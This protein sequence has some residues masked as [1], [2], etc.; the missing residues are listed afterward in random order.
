MEGKTWPESCRHPV[1]ASLLVWVLLPSSGFLTFAT[2]M[3]PLGLSFPAGCSHCGTSVRE[4]TALLAT[5][6]GFQFLD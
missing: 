4:A 2:L 3:L 6:S 1:S 5:T